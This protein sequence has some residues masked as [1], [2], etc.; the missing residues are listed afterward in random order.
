[1]LIPSIDIVAGRAVQLVGGEEERIDGGDPFAW[2]ERFSRCGEVAVV[3]I[4]AARGDGENTELI[5]EM[6]RLADVRVGGGIR[7]LASA[8]EW[9]D[10]GA[11]RVVIGTAAT[12]DLLSALPR[13]RVIAAIDSRDSSVLSHGWR[14]DTGEGLLDRVSTL[15]PFCSGIL[16]TFV[17]LEGRLGGTD[18]ARARSVVDAAADTRITVAGGVT[19]AVEIAALDEIGADAQV[20][21]ALYSGQLGLAEALTA[22]M[23]SDRPDGLWPTVVVDDA[24]TALGLAY[25]NLDSV[26]AALESGAGVYQS[27]SRGRWRKGES[28]GATQELLGVALDCDRDTL[29]FTVRQEHPGFCHTGSRSCWG[30]DAGLARLG[31]RLAAVA[32][33]PATGSNTAKLLDDPD[34]LTAKLTEEAAELA[35]AASPEDV[36]HEVADLIYFALVKATGAGVSVAEIEAELDSRERMISRRGMERSGQ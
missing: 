9:L 32:A 29:R 1:M 2:L 24:G 15:A 33:D 13:D 10:H 14:Q 8:V 31:R 6:C 27:R 22:P 18:L 16:V 28:S 3:D 19:T 34:L 36:V 21:M 12:P 11:R 5:A 30:D 35:V 4:D 17:E 7:D 23:T 26:A 25:S 20:G